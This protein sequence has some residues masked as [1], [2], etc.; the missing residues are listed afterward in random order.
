MNDIMWQVLVWRVSF[1]VQI[2]KVTNS[3]RSFM[4]QMIELVKGNILAHEPIP[5]AIST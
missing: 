2:E 3:A 1:V 4:L 5:L